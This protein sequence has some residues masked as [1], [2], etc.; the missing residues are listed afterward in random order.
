MKPTGLRN[1]GEGADYLVIGPAQFLDLVEP[2]LE[3]RREQ[4]LRAKAV[5]I[6]GV[7]D[8][9]G[10]GETRPEAVQNFIA[11]AYHHWPEPSPR[12]VLL[13]G[14]GSH[15][16]KNYLQTG[17]ENHVPPLMVRTSYIWTASD[18][19]MA[20]VNG[21]DLLPDVA[22]GRL[23]AADRGELRAMVGKI[24]AFERGQ[25]N[26]EST[27][28]LLTDNPDAAG[29]F[30]ANAQ[31]IARGVL[32]GR[33]V[34]Q[35]HLGELGRQSTRTRIFEAFDQGASLV[36]YIGH[37]AIHLWAN[38]NIFNIWDV[39]SLAPQS[40]QPLFITMNCLNGYFHFPYFNS[41]AEELVKAESKG[42]IAAFAP[43]GFSLDSPAHVFHKSLLNELF[44]GGHARLGD[45]VLAAQAAYVESGAFPELL[46]I[47][48]LLGDPALMIK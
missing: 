47:Y 20:A 45:A 12:Y 28:Y 40:Q 13:V 35:I 38:E 17:V 37:G 24:L 27:L 48:H 33:N 19:T 25:A 26:L 42:A 16:F 10:F 32:S 36:S 43:S 18:P 44:N 23:P 14:D 22:L 2:L 21:D 4:G 39:P 5:P 41:L 3:L 29:D 1:E 30:E 7:Y 15:D 31:E 11:Y 6:E 8:D 34:Q 9:F 46:S